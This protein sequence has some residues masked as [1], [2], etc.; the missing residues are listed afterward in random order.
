M[1]GWVIK[2]AKPGPLRG[3]FNSSRDGAA[4]M[5]AARRDAPALGHVIGRRAAALLAGACSL[6]LIPETSVASALERAH[7]DLAGALAQLNPYNAIGLAAFTGLVIFAT[8]TALLYLRERRRWAERERGLAQRLAELR[9]AQDRA[10]LLTA[11]ERQLVIAWGGR[12]GAPRLEGDISIMPSHAVD[13]QLDFASWLVP[14]DASRLEAAL[15]RLKERGEA[16]HLSVRTSAQHFFEAEGRTLSGQALLRLRDVTGDRLELLRCREDLGS[17][18][19]ELRNLHGLLNSIDQPVWLRGRDGAI[20]WANQAYLTA[21]DAKDLDAVRSRSLELLDRPTREEAERLRGQNLPFHTRVAAIVFGSRHVLDICESPAPEGS[22]GI[23]IDVSELEAVRSDLQQQMQ[24]HARTLDQ[25]PTAVAIFDAKQHLVFHNAAYRQLWGIEQALL[26]TRPSDSEIL[27]R[28]RAARKLPEQADYR[29][30][31]ANVLAAYRAAGPQEN[32]W[33]LPDGRSLRVVTSPNPQ[34]GLTYLFDDVSE[35]V[36][37]EA[38]Y[39]GLIRVQG[40]TLDTLTEGV[41]VFGTDGRLKLSNRAFGK[42][43]KLTPEAIAAQPHIDE[44][45][46]LCTPLFA[47]E[48]AW[49]DMRGAIAGLPE[50]RMGVSCRMERRDGSVF[51]CAAQP[52]PDGATLLTFIDMTAGVNVERALTEKNEALERAARLRDEFVH[53]V[54]YELRSPLTNIIGFTQL[55]GDETIGALNPRQREY[56]SHIMRSSSALLAMIN[57]ILD[58]ASIDTGAMELGRE[59]VDIRDTIEAAARGIED[60]LAESAVTLH[61]E[62]PANIGSFIADAKRVRQILFNL[63]SNAVGFSSPGQSIRVTANKTAGE[64]VL[65]V[66]DQ[67]RGIP[68]E[69]KAKVFER[70]ESHTLGTRHRGVGLG[71]SIVRSFVELHGGRV[72]LAST[73]DAGTTVTC[74][75]P[76]DGAPER[77]AAA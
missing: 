12:G 38:R 14:A 5:A 31:K 59:T 8:A 33:H 64:V 50:M 35:R 63:L 17:V 20:A 71:L 23:A 11:A 9:A 25:L 40:E 30:W 76:A 3:P 55:L 66:T 28:L 26:D 74:I 68:A 47:D 73:P 27:D 2:A 77:L 36:H 22:A 18:R 13:Q 1:R 52:L 67:G 72:E 10:D 45:I 70:F 51:D 53:H 48:G 56:A 15:A 16:F 34:G 42:I 39:N 46:K 41:A 44:V 49:G 21:L 7:A 37:L 19:G 75:F 69:V 43:W 61:I 4:V 57:D 24:A 60:R 58:L 29:G 62:T 65:Q 54:S 6:S 32:W